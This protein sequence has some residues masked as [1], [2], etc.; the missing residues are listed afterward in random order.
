MRR[1]GALLVVIALVLLAGAWFAFGRS[2]VE[3]ASTVDPDVT[4][5]CD[6]WTSFSPEAC[7]S[8]GDEI[9]AQGAPSHT[10]EMDDLA[11]LAISRP[12]FGLAAACRVQYFLERYANDPAWTDEVACVAG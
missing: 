5:T 8:W 6:A 2:G 4:V 12:T 10:F 1:I 7:R 9:L 11:R 3:A